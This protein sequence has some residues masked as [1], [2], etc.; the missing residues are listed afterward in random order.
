MDIELLR[1][2]LE[3]KNTRHFGKAAENLYL[4][5]AAVSARLKQLETIVGAKLFTRLRNN[6]QLTATGERLVNHAETILIAWER[7]KQDVALKQKQHVITLAGT[8]G[9]WD[10]VLQDT[11]HKVHREHP[12]LTIRAE[13]NTSEALIR[14][15]MERTVDLALLYEPAKISDLKSIDIA[16]AELILVSSNPAH[17]ASEAASSNY[18]AVDWGISFKMNFAKLY[19]DAQPPVLHTSLS[20]LA[21]DFILDFGGSAYLPYRMVEP[22]LEKQLHQVMNAPVISRQI[23]ACYHKENIHF[24]DI[25]SILSVIQSLEVPVEEVPEEIKI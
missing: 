19:P 16:P 21:L 17:I 23:Y 2:F 10:L 3:V 25:E 8:S 4:T 6:L 22:Y 18:V 13:S 20:R 24:K 15:L 11:L 7:A 1:T 5:Q 9:L 14:G 12:N